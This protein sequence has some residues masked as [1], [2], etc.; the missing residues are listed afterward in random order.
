MN[1]LIRLFIVLSLVIGTSRADQFQLKLKE[2]ETTG[3]FDL[4]YAKVSITGEHGFNG[5]TDKL[6]RITI[7]G[8]PIGNY[9]AKVLDSRGQGKSASFNIDGQQTL[10]DVYVQ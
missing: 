5:I 7:T 1:N 8:L 2:S 10:K 6:G 3:G 4:S 9:P